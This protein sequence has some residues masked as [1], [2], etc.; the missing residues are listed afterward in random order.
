ME[1]KNIKPI[2]AEYKRTSSGQQDLQLQTS[3]NAEFLISSHSEE[4]L[5]FTDF[6]VSATKLTM[7]ERPALMRMI[8]LIENGRIDRVVV[9]E[10]DRLARNVYEYIYIVKIFYEHNVEV[11]F[12]ASDAP[13]FSEDLFIEAW[14]GLS[15][16]MEGR[17]ISTRLSDSRKRN[18]PSIIGFIKKIVNHENGQSE[19]FYTPDPKIKDELQN[20]FTEF[21]EVKSREEIFE[22]LLKYRA[23]LNR[24]ELRVLEILRTPFFTAHYD[25]PNGTYYKLDKVEPIISLELFKKVQAILDEFED[26]I[27]HGISVSQKSAHIIPICGKCQNAL[28]FKKGRIG[29]SGTYFCSKHKK[30]TISV[31]ELHETII[32]SLKMTL[33][34]IK[35]E[36]IEKI[37]QKAIKNQI[38]NGNK[39]HDETYAQLETLCIKFSTL[40]KINDDSIT[41]KRLINQIDKLKEKLIVIENQLASLQNL[42]SEVNMLIELATFNLTSLTEKDYFELADLLISKIQVKDDYVLLHYYFSD[43][44]AEGDERKV[45]DVR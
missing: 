5:T 26:R 43:F 32:E 28:K 18:P 6:D 27:N 8:K 10:R 14:Y 25:G 9:Y 21:A 19:R 23:L 7:D 36:S 1:R 13:S 31:T 30:N 34:Q 22:V 24:N 37:V 41:V 16:Q 20:L 17:R 4:I 38:R 42:K 11:L 29:E 12:T 15:A 44:F 40:Y 2:I 3:S 45:V 33:N 39:N 35:F